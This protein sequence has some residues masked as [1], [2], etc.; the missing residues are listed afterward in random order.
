MD[1]VTRFERLL[2]GK[3]ANCEGR[4]D[5]HEI[6]SDKGVVYDGRVVE[7]LYSIYIY[8][9]IYRQRLMNYVSACTTSRILHSPCSTKG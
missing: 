8:I 1:N 2:D 9:Y 4:V 3:K 7:K 5:L 6:D